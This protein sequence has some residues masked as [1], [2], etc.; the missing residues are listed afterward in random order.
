MKVGWLFVEGGV[1]T[2][3]ADRDRQIH[4]VNAFRQIAYY[5]SEAVGGVVHC[6]FE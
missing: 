6:L 5:P 3:V 1:N 2:L 4:E